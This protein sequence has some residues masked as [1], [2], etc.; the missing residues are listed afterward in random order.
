MGGNK[1]LIMTD[2]VPPLLLL[3]KLTFG[4]DQFLD[5][6]EPRPSVGP[7]LNPYPHSGVCVCVCVCV[8]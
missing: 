1:L 8:W 7:V 4:D 5:H 3:L 2:F 6:H